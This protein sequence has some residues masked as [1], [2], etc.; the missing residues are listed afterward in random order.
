MLVYHY[1]QFFNFIK[2][3]LKR[4]ILKTRK[5]VNKKHLVKKNI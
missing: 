5:K 1:T 4:A 2:K 3:D